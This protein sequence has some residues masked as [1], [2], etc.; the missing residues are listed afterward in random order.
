ME[1]KAK[2]NLLLVIIGVGLFAALTNLHV[3][4]NFVEKVMGII[5]PVIVGGILALFINV[6]M[7]GIEKCLRRVWGKRKKK[8]FDKFCRF[9]VN[10]K[11]DFIRR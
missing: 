7:A 2:Q 6:P 10:F 5:L 4:L 3:V 1:K 11:L 8:P 9:V